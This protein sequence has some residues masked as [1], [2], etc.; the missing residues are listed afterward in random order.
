MKKYF[1]ILVVLFAI[2]AILSMSGCTRVE[3]GYVGIKVVYGG[4]DKGV[5]DF[6]AQTG[7]VFYFPGVSTVFEYPTYVQTA[8]WTKDQTEGSDSNEE[9]T[10][11]T[12]EGL[13]VSGDISLAYQLLPEKVPYFYVKFRS[14]DLEH[15]THGFL[16]NI[17]RDA[18]NEV[19]AKYGV[20]DVYGAKK[21]EF[22]KEIKTYVNSQVVPYGLKIEQFGFIGALRIPQNV[23]A[24]LDAKIQATQDA[25]RSENQVRQAKA[26]AEKMV[27]I[28]R[29]K[30]E[31][32]TLLNN[33]ITPTLLEWER[34]Q[35]ARQTIEKWNG[36][37]PTVEG[38][39][40]LLFTLP[41]K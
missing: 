2:F 1:N 30:S 19:G 26:E 41:A 6:P 9:I 23:K 14:D 35:V 22:L 27:A 13:V 5:N 24:A 37:R 31:S 3:P 36:V 10:F 16:R 39:S 11:N 7:W 8:V 33:S 25:I 21:E 38:N 28:A 17:A 20:E 15:F 40:N 18:F 32:N 34:L 29:G 4:G 12:K